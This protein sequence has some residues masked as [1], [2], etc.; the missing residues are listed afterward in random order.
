MQKRTD[1]I[2]QSVNLAG[3]MH[4]NQLAEQFAVSVETI[5]RDLN[6]LSKQGLLYRT[7][8]GAVSRKTK[9]IGSSFQSRQRSNYDEKRRIA[10]A[11]I[12]YVFEGAVIGLDASSSSWHFAHLI[13]D[14]PCTVVTNSMHNIT[15]LVNKTNVTTIATGGVYSS[16]YD[17]F[18]G[19][20][21]EQLLL[22]LHIDIGIFSCTGLD[23]QGDIWES[24]ELN[25]S[26]KRKMMDASGQKFLF[27][28][29]S[30]F[31]QKNLI[32]LATLD[33]MDILFTNQKPSTELQTYCDAHNV[34]LTLT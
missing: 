22:R 10:E 2:L 29:H 4:V 3:K 11:A 12:S 6:S 27:V 1:L 24:N 34:L 9:D 32:K 31:N 16:K 15:A 17:A 26:V 28:D 13:P 20:L 19:P 30:K 25:A 8:G 23:E 21:S 18:Y 5:R 7:H 33:Q 14:I